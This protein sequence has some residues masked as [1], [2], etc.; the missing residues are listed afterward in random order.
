MK[1]DSAPLSRGPRR[2]LP[3]LERVVGPFAT[4]GRST[5]SISDGSAPIDLAC[6]G[7]VTIDVSVQPDGT[8]R[9]AL[10]GDAIFAVLAAR[11]VGG[12]ANWLAPLGRDFPDALFER[13]ERAGIGQRRPLRRDLESVRNVIT[14]DAAGGRHWD[15][16]TGRDHFDRMSVYPADVPDGVLTASGCLVLAMSVPSQLALMPWLRAHT[17]ATIYL[18]LE[19]DGIPGN[20]ESLRGLLSSCDVFLPSEIE[21]LRLTGAS[22]VVAAAKE[23]SSL[24]PATVVV[25]RAERGCLILH[26]GGLTEV[27][28]DPVHPV[29]PTGAGDAFCGA[30]AATHLRNGDP[31]EAARV[32]AGVARLA[33]GGH[34]VEALLDEAI[35]RRERR[36]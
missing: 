24:G 17:S 22:D 12:R 13:L 11:H 27:P 9:E 36:P 20:E 34:G 16:V 6:I 25:K 4:D 29:D 7:N 18:D 19:E 1:S 28:T 31:I 14:Y 30:F 8:R 32:A 21:A 5:G 26:A 23:L 2:W 33:I 15:L 35:E 3:P 10:G